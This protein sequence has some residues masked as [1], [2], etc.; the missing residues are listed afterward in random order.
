MVPRTSFHV[1]ASRRVCDEDGSV[2]RVS[3]AAWTAGKRRTRGV[4]LPGSFPARLY[5]AAGYTPIGVA[6]GDLNGDGALDIVTSQALT[7][8]M[9][10][11]LSGRAERPGASDP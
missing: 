4:F 9:A 10:V 3:W 6:L 11:I 8:D 2:A 7:D 5:H 1:D